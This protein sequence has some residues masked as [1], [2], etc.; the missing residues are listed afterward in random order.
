LQ[1]SAD[2]LDR[3]QNFSKL[4]S[5]CDDEKPDVIAHLAAQ[6]GVRYSLENPRDYI[7]SNIVGTFNIME[8]ARE[9]GIEH[10]MI[11]STSSA[12]GGNE[13]MPFVE[14]EKADTQLT[15]YAA[16][17]KATEA[18][19]HSYAGFADDHVPFFY[20]LWSMGKARYGAVQIHQG[21][22]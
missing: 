22:P 15:I 7:N 4:K 8:C 5:L 21:D 6:A 13:E 10:L 2:Q 19:A 18:M 1:A 16:S 3:H 11:A 14:T 9:L 17:K 12:Y 20:R